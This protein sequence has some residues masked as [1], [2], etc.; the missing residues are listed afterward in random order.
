MRLSF[1]V[2]LAVAGLVV[3]P[4]AHAAKPKPK[5]KPKAEQ[6]AGEPADAGQGEP[7]G[8]RLQTTAG[9]AQGV[10][11]DVATIQV[12]E[13]YEFVA[14][15]Q[16]PLLNK[17][18]GNL[19]N[20]KD[21]G[22][23]LA[24]DGWL[25]FFTWDPIGYVKDDDKDDLDGDELLETFQEAEEG[26]NEARVEQGFAPMYIQGWKTP[27]HYDEKTNNL[28]WALSN[29]VGPDLGEQSVFNINHEVRML[30]R[31]GAM[32]AVLVAD[33]ASLDKA[34]AALDGM[35]TGFKF[36]SGQ[37]YAEYVKGDKVA[38]YGLAGLVLGG[39]LLA[40]GKLGILAKLGKFIKVIVLA[41]AA[42][43]VGIFRF[44]KARFRGDV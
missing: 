10:L 34:I 2:A 26:A 1:A 8:P 13:G 28:T 32:S 37:S 24:P 6:P 4:S 43:V 29:R 30:G 18:T 9:P 3:S 39:G 16:M 15:G 7:A 11:S 17:L 40:A 20:P 5:P 42:G 31:R 21:I 44:L 25:I 22:A 27:P 36:T 12:P 19:N 14:Q 38:A 35:L 41:G 33:P 23:I